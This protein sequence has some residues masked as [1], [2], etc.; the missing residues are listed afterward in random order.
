MRWIMLTHHASEAS[1]AEE[2]IAA[3]NV[4]YVGADGNRGLVRSVEIAHVGYELAQ[5]LGPACFAAAGPAQLVAVGAPD[6]RRCSVVGAVL[7]DRCQRRDVGLDLHQCAHV[8]QEGSCESMSQGVDFNL[9]G[10]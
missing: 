7:D 4:G 3:R 5:A 1:R 2:S 9:N 8:L 10:L 6:H